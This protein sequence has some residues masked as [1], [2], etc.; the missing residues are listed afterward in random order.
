MIVRSL[1]RVEYAPT[2]SAM[3]NFTDGRVADTPDELW[4]CEHQ[5]VFTQGL[6]GKSDHV[7]VPGDW[8]VVRGHDLLEEVEV[9]VRGVLPGAHVHTHLEPREDPRSY[10]DAA[11]GFSVP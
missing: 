1:G 3:Q 4:L 11:G 9:A 6:A 7:L 8:T 2:Y 10:D 5:P